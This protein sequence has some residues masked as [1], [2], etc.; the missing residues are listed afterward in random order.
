M[1][2]V[3]NI[4]KML[5]I[6][7]LSASSSAPLSEKNKQYHSAFATHIVVIDGIARTGTVLE[8]QQWI[9]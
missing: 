7:T 3:F 1:L 2:E 4:N 9:D 6:F 5:V 8:L